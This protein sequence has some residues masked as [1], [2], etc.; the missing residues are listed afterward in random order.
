[1]DIVDQKAHRK[2]YMRNLMRK[3]YWDNKGFT[4][5]VVKQLLEVLAGI[6]KV[7]ASNQEAINELLAG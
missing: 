4:P 1:M 2:E 3:R 6:A 7:Q 5:K